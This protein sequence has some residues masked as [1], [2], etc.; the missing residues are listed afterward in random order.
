MAI[1]SIPRG[2]LLFHRCFSLARQVLLD[3][4]MAEPEHEQGCIALAKEL[5]TTILLWIAKM[6]SIS[7]ARRSAGLW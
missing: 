6:L 2:S 3:D 1:R 4:G 5:E 7:H